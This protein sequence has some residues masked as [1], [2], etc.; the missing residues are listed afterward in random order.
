MWLIVCAYIVTTDVWEPVLDLLCKG[1]T[2]FM[3]SWFCVTPGHLRSSNTNNV[4]KAQ[5]F[6]S[7]L[8]FNH[9]ATYTE[10]FKLIWALVT[11]FL[12][13]CYMVK[14]NLCHP[15]TLWLS[16]EVFLHTRFENQYIIIYLSLFCS[17]T[18]EDHNKSVYLGIHTLLCLF[19]AF[20]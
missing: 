8:V 14:C 2:K 15:G 7:H 10:W 5:L 9:N 1:F 6:P 16:E 4:T 11:T 12:F 20:K 3:S 13:C 18:I 19:W 17:Y